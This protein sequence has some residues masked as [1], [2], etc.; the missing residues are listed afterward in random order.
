M[1][2]SETARRREAKRTRCFQKKERTIRKKCQQTSE[3]SAT[4][5]RSDAKGEART[6]GH[7]QSKTS[8]QGQR[9]SQTPRKD[10]S[11][12]QMGAVNMG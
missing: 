5:W 4:E 12:R 6:E 2:R 11:R 1:R 3:Y 9:F 7:E 8:T 10:L